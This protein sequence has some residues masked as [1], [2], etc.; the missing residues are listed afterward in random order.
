MAK[1]LMIL[2][3]TQLQISS[4]H[5]K[6]EKETIVACICNTMPNWVETGGFRS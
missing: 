5:V 1:V 4:S 6:K 2:V 3:R